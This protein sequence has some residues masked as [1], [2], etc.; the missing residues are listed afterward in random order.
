[1]DSKYDIVHIQMD[2]RH[3]LF[4]PFIITHN[5]KQVYNVPYLAPRTDKRG[6][7]VAIKTKSRGRIDSNDIEAKV[8]YQ[9]KEMSYVKD[10]IEVKEVI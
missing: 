10:I 2:K 6:W 1:M 7:C 4:D 9:V 5:V 8:A 3:V